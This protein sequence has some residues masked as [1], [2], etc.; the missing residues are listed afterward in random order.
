MRFTHDWNAEIGP[1]SS[2]S[3]KCVG[4][5]KI[6]I[7]VHYYALQIWMW[8]EIGAITIKCVYVCDESRGELE[9]TDM[10]A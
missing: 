5:L 8:N 1:C 4:W 6:Q 7:L 2:A 10:T 3:D 9:K